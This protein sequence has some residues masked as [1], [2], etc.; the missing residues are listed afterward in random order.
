MAAAVEAANQNLKELDRLRK[1]QDIIIRKINKIHERLSQTPPETAERYAEKLWIKLKGC[2]LEAKS[3]AEKEESISSQCITQLDTLITPAQTAPHRRKPD[4]PEQKRKRMKADAESSRL[5]SPAVLPR[6]P[7][8]YS[9]ISV[10]D[11][12]A[13][14]VTSMD[15]DKDE[16]IVVKVIRFDRDTN[17][18]EV[19]DEEPGDDEENG[20]RKYKLPPP[21]IIPFPKRTD[22][23]TALDFGT[24]SQVLA[25]Y[26][27][28]TALYKATVV[29][30]HRK[31][32][33]D[34]YIL[35]FDDDE[36]DGVAGLPK[37][38]VPF[39]HVVQLPEGHRQ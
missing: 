7:V 15:A 20:Q 32:K 13:A 37:R 28:T 11:Q 8:D 3:L 5:N 27:G 29:G 17:K 35:E 23:S 18:Y 26:P 9:S 2:Y 39:Y 12:V 4:V 31:K 22:P 25:V 19:I 10:E 1:E 34:D 21:C 24:G 16:W 14:R 33:S 6:M 30:P 38:P 36:E